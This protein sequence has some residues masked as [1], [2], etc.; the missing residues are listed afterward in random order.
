MIASPSA[1]IAAAE[2]LEELVELGWRADVCPLCGVARGCSH[3]PECLAERAGLVVRQLDGG[4]PLT[5]A[6]RRRG[7]RP[8]TV[9]A[10]LAGRA[11]ADAAREAVRS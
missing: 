5:P 4:N 8:G 10:K 7:H 1:V 3:D 2:L 6:P 11:A 9:A